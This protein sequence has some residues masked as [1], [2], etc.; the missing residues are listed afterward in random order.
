MAEFCVDCWNKINGTNY[1]QSRYILSEEPDLCEECGEVKK[2]IIAEKKTGIY[3]RLRYITL[4]SEFIYAIIKRV[5]RL[6]FN[7][8]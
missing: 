3:K 8:K 7:R 6:L 1:P 4:P 5:H 2:V